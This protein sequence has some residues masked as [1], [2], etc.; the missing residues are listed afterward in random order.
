MKKLTNLL[1]RYLGLTA[2]L[3][4]FILGLT[5]CLMVLIK[6]FAKQSGNESLRSV[7]GFLKSGHMR[8]WIDAEASDTIVGVLMIGFLLLLI[9]GFFMWLRTKCWWPRGKRTKRSRL[10][11]LHTLLG[12]YLLPLLLYF[13]VTATLCSLPALRGMVGLEESW[14]S[15]F[16]VHSGHFWGS[17]GKWIA[18]LSGLA[19]TVLSFTGLLIWWNKQ[20][21]HK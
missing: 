16:C 11:Y 4:T 7:V 2:G 9:T 21:M 6:P 14:R 5:G 10:F 17:A 19:V 13:A 15:F 20:K 1:H 3:A 12:L 8:L 18:G